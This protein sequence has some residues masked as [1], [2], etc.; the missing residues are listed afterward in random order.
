[1]AEIRAAIAACNLFVVIGS[2]GTVYPAAGF[3]STA[4]ECGIRTL[5]INLDYPA[6]A[7]S[8]DEMMTGSATHMVP[9]WV[10]QVLGVA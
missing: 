3:A 4:R 7:R 6:G 10:E 8:F 2:S 5:S 9:R 1:M